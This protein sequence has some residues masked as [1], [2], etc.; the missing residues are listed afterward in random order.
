[1]NRDMKCGNSGICQEMQNFEGFG[2]FTDANVSHDSNSHI[3]SS[4][5]SAKNPKTREIF[6][7]KLVRWILHNKYLNIIRY[8]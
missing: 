6:T 5:V 3:T 8:N 1:M 2:D 7:Q 4:E